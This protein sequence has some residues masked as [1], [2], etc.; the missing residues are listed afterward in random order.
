VTKQVTDHVTSRVLGALTE[1]ASNQGEFNKSLADAIVNIGHGIQ[2]TIQQQEQI[3]QAPAGAPKS[4]MRVAPAPG[5]PNLQVL[6]KSQGEQQLTKAQVL[7]RMGDL[8]EKGKLNS[9][10][11]IKFEM[12]GQMGPAVED[13]V[14]KSFQAG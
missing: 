13:L 6:S 8:V 12:T 9:L 4:Q 2:G 5:R 10:D 14:M 1:F 3:A 7:D 11:V